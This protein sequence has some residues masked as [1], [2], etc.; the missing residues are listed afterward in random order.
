MGDINAMLARYADAARRGGTDGCVC[1]PDG[2]PF[3]AGHYDDVSQMPP[4]AVRASL[5]CGNPT[6]VAELRPGDTVL[7]LGS[8]GGLDVLLSA[9]RVGPTGLVYGLDATREMVDLARRNA[10]DAGVSNVEFLDGTIEHI[11]LDDASVDVVISNCVI[12]LSD[13]KDVVFAE[14]ARVLRPGGHL[15]VSDIVRVAGDDASPCA[16]DCAATAITVDTYEDALRRTGLAL[17]SIEPT[18]PLGGGLS[19]A[20][21]KATKP[22]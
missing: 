4:A 8:G 21:V 22:G 19:N 12:V 3:G 6:T 7:D 17:V 16:V 20:I 9:R 1:S 2:S 5:G 15:G 13:D 18:E 11:P 14:I 10:S